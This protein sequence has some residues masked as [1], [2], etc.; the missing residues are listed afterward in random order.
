MLKDQYHNGGGELSA[1]AIALR[2]A[3]AFILN[4]GQ[5]HLLILD[6]VLTAMSSDR[7]QLIL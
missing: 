6:E 2:L 3:I 5:Q 7:P 4:N 1:A